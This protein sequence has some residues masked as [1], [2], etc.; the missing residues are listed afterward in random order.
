MGS[1]VYGVHLVKQH[2][3]YC[4][5][6]PNQRNTEYFPISPG[7][8]PI[9]QNFQYQLP[10]THYGGRIKPHSKSWIYGLP[11]DYV[12]LILLEYVK[13]LFF[14]VKTSPLLAYNL[15]KL[16]RNTEIKMQILKKNQRA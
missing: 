5:D 15:S 3:Q 4:T 12:P 14:M 13:Q 1:Q 8:L 11:D 7:V 10:S 2:L 9:F 16:H 6:R